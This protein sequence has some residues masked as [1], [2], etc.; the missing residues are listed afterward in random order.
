M[1]LPAKAMRCAGCRACIGSAGHNAESEAFARAAIEQLET[2]PPGPELAMAYIE[3]RAARDARRP[4]LP[5]AQQWGARAITL[6]ELLGDDEVLVHALNN[7]GS[8]EQRDELPGGEE[9]LRRSLEL[10]LAGGLEEHA[11]RA[12]CNLTAMAVQRRRPADDLFADGLGYCERHDLDSWRAYIVAWRAVAELNAGDYDAAAKAANDMLTHSRTAQITRIPALVALGLVRARRGDPGAMEPLDQALALARPT[13]ELQRLGQVASARA[14]VAWLLSDPD[15]VHEETEIAWELAQGR[16][17]RWLT[18]ELALWR[19]R[20]GVVDEVPDW[21]VEPY[22][23][24]LAGRTEE[25]AA[26]WTALGC[27]YEAAVAAADLDALA[28][29][30]A[31]AAVLRLR[32]RGPRAATRQNPGGLTARELEVL[33]LVA[34]GL[35]NAEIADRLV[36]SRR[37]VDHHVSAILMK[38]DVSTRAGAVAKMGNVTD[39]GAPAR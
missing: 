6:A 24:E 1:T 32:R 3:S 19:R 14:E 11:A 4:T 9:K 29:L 26:A 20:G 34:E 33:T 23:L 27:P 2:L 31:R 25:G 22:A 21:V 36:V 30:G 39:E 13:G 35:T 16:R 38:L 17:E 5:A 10:A 28:R 12:Y 15:R 7:V 18:A 37:T 8:A